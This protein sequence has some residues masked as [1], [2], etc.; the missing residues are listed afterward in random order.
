MH[1]II[2][3]AAYFLLVFIVSSC[4]SE[5]T[6]PAS[7]QADIDYDIILSENK[8]PVSYIN[9]ARPILEQRCIVCHGCY[10]A[11]CQLKLTSVD[12]I[13]RG[14]NPE[15]VYDAE[16]ILAAEPTRMH[17]DAITE[18]EWRQKGFHTVLNNQQDNALNNLRHSV[19]YKMLRLK[20][21]NPQP[22]V[23]MIDKRIELG[24]NREQSCPTNS[25][26]ADYANDFPMQGMPFAMPNLSDVEY[27]TLVKWISQGLPDDSKKEPSSFAENEIEKWEAFLNITD[28]KHRLFSRYLYEHL[29]LG[30]LYFKGGAER[31]FFRLVR[32]YTPPGVEIKEIAT[33]RVFDDPG[34][35]KFYYRLKRYTSSIVDKSHIIYEL[36]DQ[37]MTRYKDLFIQPDYQV[38][39]LPS[40]DAKIAS[41]PFKT[42]VDIP[43]KSRYQFL[44]DDAKYFIEG[45]I[46]GPVCRGQVALNVIEDNFWVFFS[47]PEKIAVNNNSHYLDK[48]AEELRLPAEQG[49]TLNLLSIWTRYWESQHEYM[50]TR[51]QQFE[52][53]KKMNVQEAMNYIWN[54][55]SSSNE[56]NRALTIFRHFDSASVKQ[57][58]LGDYPETSWVLDYPLLERIHYLLVAGYD[59]YGNIGHQVNTR[60]FMD[61]LR[62]EAENNFLAFL[63]VSHRKK[64]QDSWYQGIREN[65]KAIFDQ[66]SDWLDVQ[67]VFG[68]KTNDPQREFYQLLED[69]LISSADEK[70]L[71]NRCYREQCNKPEVLSPV[72]Q[73]LGKIS[74]IKGEILS[75]FP[76]VALLKINRDGGDTDE[77]YTFIHNKAYKNISFILDDL[78]GRDKSMDSLTVYKGVLGAYP[79][80]F[81][82]VDEN[83]IGNFTERLINIKN[84]DDY[85]RF[86]GL[87]GVRRT[88]S[89]FWSVVDWMHQQHAKQ[90]PRAYGVLDLYRYSNQ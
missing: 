59:V 24:L 5:K 51:Q 41:N 63:P 17:V 37:R 90:S 80:F 72:E 9:Q 14:A 25:E 83:D 53:M 86:V 6:D 48:M 39:D 29:F 84:R 28:N 1:K 3:I 45:F 81:Y 66:P 13:K 32:S 49:N 88:A 23:G 30:H 85:E 21:L 60:L 34:I 2:K 65:I 67:V 68:F 75:V 4:G 47:D 19:L 57:G 78:D 8:K 61:F 38:T 56:N 31:E 77:V 87:Y 58:L 74:K 42:F 12:A 43:V 33:V 15:K 22:R 71:I 11:P 73:Q 10:D 62:M 89:D 55:K 7:E 18:A 52:T 70:D 79:N 26:Y 27:H 64:I 69:R 16:R 44:L 46:K 76:E 20:Q 54:G 40:Y 82:T 50:L 35:G 36:S